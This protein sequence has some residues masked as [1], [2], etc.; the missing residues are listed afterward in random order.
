MTMPF[1][2]EE[3]CIINLL[4]KS[5]NKVDILNAINNMIKYSDYEELKEALSS[6]YAKISSLN[7]RNLEQLY[8]DKSSNRVTTCPLYELV[9]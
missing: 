9:L 2:F 6:L 1:T 3:V 7:E 5:S 4:V 8:S